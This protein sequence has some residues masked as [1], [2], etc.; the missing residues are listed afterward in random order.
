MYKSRGRFRSE[1]ES[2]VVQENWYQREQL[3]EEALRIQKLIDRI[4]KLDVIVEARWVI[5]EE[6]AKKEAELELRLAIIRQF[7]RRAI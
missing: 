2:K 6:K 3:F 4:H 7:Q 1:V 5:L